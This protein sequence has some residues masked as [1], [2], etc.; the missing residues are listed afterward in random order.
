MSMEETYKLCSVT[1]E[2]QGNGKEKTAIKE[3]HSELTKDG[4]LETKYAILRYSS[5]NT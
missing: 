5:P 1:G 2:K 4:F 3:F